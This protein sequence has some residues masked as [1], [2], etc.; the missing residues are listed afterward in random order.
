MSAT[1]ETS[2]GHA[3]SDASWLDSHFQ[4]A[5]PEYEESLRYVGIKPGW[6]VLDA[7]C[8][9]GGFLPWLSEQVGPAGSV[10]ALD[11]APENILAV[12]TNAIAAGFAENVQ[13]KVGSILA[14]PFADA[15]FDCVWSA[16]VMQY[17]TDVEAAQA[18]A[19][20]IRVLKPGGTLALKDGD[21][22]HWEMIPLNR[23]MFDRFMSVH[24][25]KTRAGN[26][27]TAWE[28]GTSLSSRL[29]RAGLLEIRRKAWLVERWAPLPPATRRFAQELLQ[30]WAGRAATY[31]AIGAD[32]QFWQ[33]Y[34]A[35]PER[36]L[37][38]PDCCF[39]EAFTV[40]VGHKAP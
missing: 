24:R 14:L 5:R 32:A 19:E 25:A 28:C 33:D 39:R 4:S 8:G 22:Q 17:L 11:L 6:T 16:N 36:V 9:S 27:M 30:F 21:L 13:T 29:R 10:V 26:V 12:E 20:F 15:T 31:E 7:A 34:A 18:I 37:D 1:R 2:T 40:A 35:H 3:V 38:D 23:D